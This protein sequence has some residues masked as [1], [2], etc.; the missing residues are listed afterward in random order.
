MDSR[1]IFLHFAL[2]V[3]EGRRKLG[4]ACTCIRFKYV[5]SAC[6]K[7]CTHDHLR[8]DEWIKTHK[9]SIRLMLHFQEKLLSVLN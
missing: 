1:L 4:L 2:R 7:I 9:V 6:E 8:Y 5:G 3:M